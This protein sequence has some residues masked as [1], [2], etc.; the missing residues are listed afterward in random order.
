MKAMHRLAPDIVDLLTCIVRVCSAYQGSVIS[1]CRS[2]RTNKDVGGHHAS[3]HL[4]ACACDVVYDPRP[5]LGNGGK[6]E[7]YRPPL[8]LLQAE[9]ALYNVKV[10]REHG[11]DHFECS[12]LPLRMYF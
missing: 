9:C 12:Q 2:R 1:W 6:P 11:H 5:R 3:K 8:S 4:C 10:I 7:S